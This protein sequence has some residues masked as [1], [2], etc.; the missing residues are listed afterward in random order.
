MQ[1]I[2]VFL[3]ISHFY[4]H[5]HVAPALGTLHVSLS[6]NDVNI[7]SDMEQF[8]IVNDKRIMTKYHYRW[9]MDIGSHSK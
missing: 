4:T 8:C 3:D 9:K 2:N 7:G 1:F 6:V 5:N